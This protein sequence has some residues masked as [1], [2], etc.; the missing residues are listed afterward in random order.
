MVVWRQLGVPIVSVP[1]EEASDHFDW[2]AHFAATD[3][4]ASST[5]TQARM[6]W[7]PAQPA[8]IPDL[9]QGHYFTV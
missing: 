2:L 7:A 5:L 3:T 6:G 1:P 4:P 8:L 9:E